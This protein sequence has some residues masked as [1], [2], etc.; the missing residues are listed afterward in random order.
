VNERERERRNSKQQT[1]V[2]AEYF[3]INDGS[4]WQTVETVRERLPQLY[5]V[6][7]LT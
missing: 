7:T 4:D 5:I 3:L 6:P 1:A 2:A